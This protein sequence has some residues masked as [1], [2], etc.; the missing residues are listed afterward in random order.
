MPVKLTKQAVHV[1]CWI[2][3]CP[4]AGARTGA[5]PDV[6]QVLETVKQLL[7]KAKKRQ[8]ELEKNEAQ[9]TKSAKQVHTV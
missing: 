3:M 6:I 1:I 2:T 7:F 4:A 5:S 8:L 9:L